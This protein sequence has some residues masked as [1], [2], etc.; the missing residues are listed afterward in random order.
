MIWA[1]RSISPSLCRVP[2]S[3]QPTH[4]ESAA[5]VA[6]NTDTFLQSVQGEWFIKAGREKGKRQNVSDGVMKGGTLNIVGRQFEFDWRTMIELT[7]EITLRP[8][9]QLFEGELKT[10][11][12]TPDQTFAI[13]CAIGP[14]GDEL[15]VAVA[16][17]LEDKVAG[18]TKPDTIVFIFSRTKSQLSE[19]Y[20]RS[21]AKRVAKASSNEIMRQAGGGQDLVVNV[22]GY[23]HDEETAQFEIDMQASFNGSV[24]RSNNYQVTG[25]IT[26]DDDGN[27]AKFARTG[28]NENYQNLLK[29]VEGLEFAAGI[30]K[31]LNE[32]QKR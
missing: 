12:T 3:S 23:E 10:F 6:S 2:L 1:F 27:N 20:K 18:L 28:A 22:T 15:W 24:F 14:V 19:S 30:L 11:T 32:A 4:A 16:Q 21:F 5:G 31:A 17:N 29:N 25:R 26:V 13:P 8:Q 7:G 9:G